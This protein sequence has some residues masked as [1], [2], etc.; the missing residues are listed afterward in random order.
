MNKVETRD[1]EKEEEGLDEMEA[2]RG[3]N[4]RGTR[5]QLRKTVPGGISSGIK[6][7]DDSIAI[8]NDGDTASCGNVRREIEACD[9][10]LRSSALPCSI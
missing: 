7:G 10:S 6:G 1:E 3:W 9:G 2:V 8:G 5:R 4:S